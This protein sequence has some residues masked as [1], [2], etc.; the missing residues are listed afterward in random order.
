MIGHRFFAILV[1]SVLIQSVVSPAATDGAKANFSGVYAVDA[2]RTLEVYQ[3]RAVLKITET[4][5]RKTT[6]NL[7]KLDGS[8]GPYTTNDVGK[9]TCTARLSG[10]TL[11]LD[12]DATEH[13]REIHVTEKWVLSPNSKTIRVESF[14]ST[15]G[16]LGGAAGTI[17][18]RRVERKPRP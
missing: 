14:V 4:L 1:G 2:N 10:S 17:V 8:E 9:G 15:K 16:I 6:T 18:W 7:L 5:N 13:S 11:M 12:A 3:T